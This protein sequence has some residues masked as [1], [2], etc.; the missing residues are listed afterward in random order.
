MEGIYHP[1]LKIGNSSRY[2]GE[3]ADQRNEKQMRHDGRKTADKRY[4][5][6]NSRIRGK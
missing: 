2:V 6:E 1:I 5:K 3:S 4:T